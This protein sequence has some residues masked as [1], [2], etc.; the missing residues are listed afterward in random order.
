MMRGAERS[1][2]WVRNIERYT[3]LHLPARLRTQH[4]E[5]MIDYDN[6]GT[7]N[8]K[9]SDAPAP[10]SFKLHEGGP[11]HGAFPHSARRPFHGKTS[12]MC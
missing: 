9:N 12:E 2:I 8:N 10:A 3:L 5:L 6:H 7:D 1:S 4:A 11:S